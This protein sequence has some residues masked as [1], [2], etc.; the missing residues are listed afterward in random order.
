MTFGLEFL[1]DFACQPFGGAGL[2]SVEHGDLE[3]GRCGCG[4]R[5]GGAAENSPA[6]KPLSQLRCSGV[7]GALSG[8]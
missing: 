2:R 7:K 5:A 3:R 8:M 1:R 6:R 4:K